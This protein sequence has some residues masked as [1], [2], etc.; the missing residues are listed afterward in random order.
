MLDYTPSLNLIIVS[1]GCQNE[2]VVSLMAS[3]H[4]VTAIQKRGKCTCALIW[5]YMY[6]YVCVCMCV[7]ISCGY[8]STL[9]VLLYK[10]V[11][12]TLKTLSH[13]KEGNVQVSKI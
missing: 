12:F 1:C 8:V 2:H 6:V 13:V 9:Q 3:Q 7:F 10:I 5:V 4:E 11:F